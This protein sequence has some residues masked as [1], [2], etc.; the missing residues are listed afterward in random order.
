MVEVFARTDDDSGVAESAEPGE[1]LFLRR[2]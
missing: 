1:R 2:T